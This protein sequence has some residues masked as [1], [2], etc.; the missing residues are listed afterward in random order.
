LSTILRFPVTKTALNFGYFKTPTTPLRLETWSYKLMRDSKAQKSTYH[1]L[2][3]CPTRALAN[4]D[5]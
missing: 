3:L 4:V 2:N 5:S 1:G